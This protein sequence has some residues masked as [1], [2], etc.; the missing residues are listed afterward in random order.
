MRAWQKLIVNALIFVA[1]SAFIPGFYVSS[2]C[3]ATGAAIIL[4]LLNIFI[5]PIL[6]LLSLPVNLLTFGLFSIV[7][8]GIILSLTSG[9]MGDSFDFSSFWT[10]LLVAILMSLINSFIDSRTY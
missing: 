5:R 10:T 3:G 4:G 9:F 2:F 6:T 8:N 7:I 1:L